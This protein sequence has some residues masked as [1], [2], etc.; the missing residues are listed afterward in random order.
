MSFLDSTGLA[1]AVSEI[2]EYC[3]A[4]FAALRHLL[5]E[6]GSGESIMAEHASMLASMEIDGISEQ[7]SP[8]S[9]DH[10]QAIRCLCSKNMINAGGYAFVSTLASSYHQELFSDSNMSRLEAGVTYTLSMDATASTEPFGFSVG[11]WQNRTYTVIAQKDG[12]YDGHHSITFTPTQEQIDQ[13]NL[14]GGQFAVRCPAYDVTHTIN[15]SWTNVQ[16]ERGSKETAF[17]YFG[18]IGLEISSGDLLSNE[19]VEIPLPLKNWAG[20]LP[21]GTCDTLEA[22]ASGKWQWMNRVGKVVLDGSN[23]PTFVSD[24]GVASKALQDKK[25]TGSELML[26]FISTHFSPGTQVNQIYS[27]NENVY[28]K[29]PASIT[30]QAACDQFFTENP[31]TILYPLKTPEDDTFYFEMPMLSDGCSMRLIASIDAQFDAEWWI[32]GDISDAI[33]AVNSRVTDISN[34]II[35]VSRGGTGKTD[36]YDARASIAGAPV[37]YCYTGNTVSGKVAYLS[38]FSLY[39]GV[40]IFVNF[41][42]ANAASALTL[43]VNDTGAKSVYANGRVTS[44]T[45]P[46]KWKNGTILEFIYDGTYWVFTGNFISS[47]RYSNIPCIYMP[48]YN[49]G[50]Q[51]TES[52]VPVLPCRCLLGDGTDLLLTP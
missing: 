16:L 11:I 18:T 19:T 4:T 43:N 41:S 51:P 14:Y 32:N 42:Y 52:N 25:N 44:A 39:N 2:K 30:S 6:S 3:Q 46:L 35:P 8:P 5:T 15:G 37:A 33:R 34:S 12:L 10:P 50:N 47:E 21:D 28:M 38:G 40:R 45:Y 29:M 17:S 49:A 23:L 20:S 9:P 36:L 22:D 31:V 7:D 26:N 13:I 24:S 27:Y 1:Q 48:T